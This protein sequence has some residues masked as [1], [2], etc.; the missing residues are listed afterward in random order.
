MGEKLQFKNEHELKL[1]YI[2][3]DVKV[4]NCRMIIPEKGNEIVI[5]G[6]LFIR[7]DTVIEGSLKAEYLEID[8]R[9]TT[10][11]HGDLVVV[12]SVRVEKGQLEI[13]GSAT[14]NRFDVGAALSVGKD[15]QAAK[16]SIGGALSV[17]G[18]ATVEDINVGGAVK[19]G[20]KVDSKT[21]NVGGAVKCNTGTIG[22]VNVGGAFKAEGAVEI[23]DIDV[24][25]AVVVGPGSKVLNIDVGG[26]FKSEG[27]LTF[28]KLD[29]GGAAKL[30]GK[31]TGKNV[32]VGGSVKA[33]ESLVLAEKLDV[34][35]SVVVNTDLIVAGEIEVGGSLRAGN[36]IESP[37]IDIGGSIKGTRIK[38]L[39]EFRI[40]RRGEVSGFVESPDITVSERVRGAS[41]YGD[42]IRVE[43][44]AR[45][46]NLY[47]RE[48]YIERD[49]TV[50]GEV[51]YTDSIEAESG[52]H[53]RK[54]PEQVQKLPN[55]DELAKRTD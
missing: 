13:E 51:L 30:A 33:E 49:V 39:K 21:I 24:G 41:F 28:E 20:G 52:V 32:D 8:G 35:G 10:E 31:A 14:A 11:I 44:R 45:V 1:G 43:E 5:D 27:D 40:G 26:S 46:K 23:G 19:I 47:G 38:A 50:E 18:D 9:N 4:E 48:I 12:R 53:F 54:E 37:I 15:L 34:G 16:V 42:T 3:G 17:K 29:C 25:G 2:K 6:E 36:L 22:K 7:G 55:P